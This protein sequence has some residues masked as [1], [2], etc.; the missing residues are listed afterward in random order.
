MPG[1]GVGGEDCSFKRQS[2]WL[3]HG[4]WYSAALL[5]IV[6]RLAIRLHSDARAQGL[7]VLA[8]VSPALF[9]SN[10]PV[11]SL[12]TQNKSFSIFELQSQ[13]RPKYKYKFI[14][15]KD[16]VLCFVLQLSLQLC[17]SSYLFYYTLRGI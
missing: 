16:T 15:D 6:H 12:G 4:S 13:M 8:L 1:R 9:V 10:Q 17:S 5:L 11:C 2:L 7:G 3:S 14:Y